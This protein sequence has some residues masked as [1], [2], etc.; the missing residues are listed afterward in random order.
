MP[1]IFQLPQLSFHLGLH[2]DIFN[3]E[4][5]HACIITLPLN[6]LGAQEHLLETYSREIVLDLKV[7]NRDVVGYDFFQQFPEL[8][9]IPLAVSNIID[10]LVFGFRAR[11][12]EYAIELGIRGDYDK[13]GV[14]DRS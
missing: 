5:N 13:I 9:D 12:P 10:T 1:R 7:I 8:Q 4:E 3:G 11:G 2:R 14:Q 6:Q